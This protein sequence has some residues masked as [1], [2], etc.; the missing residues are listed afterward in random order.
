MPKYK[1]HYCTAQVG[2]KLTQRLIAGMKAWHA[3]LV[4]YTDQDRE[5]HE[6]VIGAGFFKP[7]GEPNIPTQ[8][9]DVVIVNQVSNEYTS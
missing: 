4:N 2:E 9:H 5:D 8:V 1:I 6:E 3:A 7:G